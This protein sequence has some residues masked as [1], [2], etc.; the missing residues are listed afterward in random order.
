MLSTRVIKCLRIMKNA[1]QHSQKQPTLTAPVRIRTDSSFCTP[2]ERSKTIANTMSTLPS[3][4]DTFK[5]FE[6]VT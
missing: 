2:L 5:K 3:F 6:D 4:D 1:R